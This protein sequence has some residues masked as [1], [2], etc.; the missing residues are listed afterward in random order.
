M[1]EDL[2]PVA[3]RSDSMAL[4]RKDQLEASA[5]LEDVSIA[6]SD[7][8]APEAPINWPAWKRN[9][10]IL[11]VAIHSMVCVFMAAGIIPGY[12][13][14]AEEYKITVPQASYLTSVQILILGIAPF[15]WIPITMRYGRYHIFIFSVLGT[16]VCN[17]GGVFCKTFGTQMATRAIAAWL[18]SPPLGIGSGVVTELCYPEERARK[19]GWWTLLIT[20][21][22]PGGAFINGFV[23]Q[24]LGV[25]WIFGIFAIINGVQ[26]I[27]Y[28]LFGDETLYVTDA[29]VSQK[30]RNGWSRF[31]PCRLDP[32]PFELQ[33]F[34]APLFLGSFPRILIPGIAYGVEFAYANIAII[35]ETPLIFGEKF[36]FNAQQVG[37]QFISIIIGSVIGEQVSGPMSD[38]FLRFLQRRNGHTIPADRLWL[39]YIGYGTVFT[40]LLVWGFQLE[41]ATTWNVT[42]C[43]GMAIAAFGNQV[44]TTILISFAVDSHKEHS[45]SIGV[46]IN[47]CRQIYGFCGPFY[48]PDMYA[49]LGL[50]G[51]AGVMCGIIAVVSL[52]PVLLIQLIDTK[53]QPRQD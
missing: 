37:Y 50:S 51:A 12:E 46:F 33:S 7:T 42:P 41:K 49:N 38:W 32:R 11:M 34:I 1:S 43:I 47:L 6:T 45:A 52:A 4:V 9:A 8:Q 48:F 53:R 15:F 18:I 29:S 40:G 39:S 26:F 2:S 10:Q 21:G 3:V 17:I 20:I 22:I 19:L 25:S 44:L 14:M 27:A 23:V 28:V 31:M 36:H 5:H 16:M 35:V 13:S 30:S 24:H